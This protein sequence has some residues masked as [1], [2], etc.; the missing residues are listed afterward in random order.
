MTIT[1]ENGKKG[2]GDKII[3][4]NELPITMLEIGQLLLILWKN[5]DTIYPPSK[6]YKG[7]QMSKDFLDEVF[8]KRD[9]TDDMLR[10]YKLGKYRPTKR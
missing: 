7:A 9:I 1:T 10:R 2:D 3:K 5:E 4:Y 6:G 8:Q